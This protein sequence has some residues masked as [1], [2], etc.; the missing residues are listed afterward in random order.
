MK[1]SCDKAVLSAAVSNV[2][3]AV[4]TRTALQALEGIL[5]RAEGDT[6]T[7]TGYDLE[8]GITTVIP[9][10]VSEEGS[11]ILGARLFGEMIRKLEGGEVFVA[12][13]D[14]LLTEIRGG[15]AEFTILGMDA[16]DYPELPGLGDAES[17][18]L[19]QHALKSMIEQ[20]QFA[21]SQNDTK[22]V[23]TGSLFDVMPDSVTV[24][25]VDGYRMAVRRELCDTG[26]ETRFV[27]PGKT[28]AEIAKL[29]SDEPAGEG[30]PE[31]TASIQVSR[32]YILTTIGSYSLVSRLLDGEFLDYQAAIPQGYTTQ[33]TVSTREL[34][35]A[36]DRASLIISD[37]LRSP[38]RLRFE[39][40]S[41]RITCTTSLGKAYDEVPCHIEGNA[42]EM[43]FNNKYVL[44][45]L[46]AAD[47]DEI[48]LQI[49]GPLSPMKVVPPEGDSFLFLVLPVRLKTEQ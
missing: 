1:F 43:G 24:V 15:G 8:L 17:L 13:D 20:T 39:E 31:K 10:E 30:E 9:A 3:R 27:V 14:K 35:A 49:S 22:P 40:D 4:T 19:P 25:S 21:I 26:L 11:I 34:I 12:S 23:H 38:L 46:R 32:Q 37:R 33:V 36:V 28:L 48:C 41:L 45:A 6:L 42:L 47:C 7:L 16:A 2:S 44:D 18:T 29:L 5:I